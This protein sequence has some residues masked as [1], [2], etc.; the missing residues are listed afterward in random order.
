VSAGERALAGHKRSFDT[1]AEIADNLHIFFI[2]GVEE[3]RW[4]RT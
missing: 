3:P 1:A 2:R 4:N